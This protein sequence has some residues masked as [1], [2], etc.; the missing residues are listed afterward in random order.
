MSHNP[1]LNVYT[2]KLNNKGD[3]FTTFRDFFKSKF[4]YGAET[5]DKIVFGRFYDEFLQLLGKDEFANDESE[6][7]V[8]GVSFLNEENNSYSVEPNFDKFTVDGILD[9]GKYGIQR[10]M[11]KTSNKGEKAIITSDN[12]VLDKF[13]FLLNT[14]FNSKYGYLI[15][16]SY[17][18]ETI[19]EPFKKKLKEIFSKNDLFHNILIQPYVPE[20]IKK[21]FHNS[22][23]VKVFSYTKNLSISGRFREGVTNDEEEFEVTI[24]FKPK[25]KLKLNEIDLSEVTK[26]I[27]EIEFDKSELNNVSPNVGLVSGPNDRRANFDLS[28]SIDKIRP[29]IYLEDEGVYVDPKTRVPKFEDIKRY[30]FDLLVKV[31]EEYLK[32]LNIDEF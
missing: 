16:Q 20:D 17:T 15:I 32:N 29:T 23:S 30:C 31:K 22:A 25:N 4:N 10:E 2:L 1:K 5:D 12:A 21:K 3:E 13:Y 19:Q 7:K 24:S 18:E 6:Q 14:P 8:I 26:E 28:K 27:G 9:G 11:A